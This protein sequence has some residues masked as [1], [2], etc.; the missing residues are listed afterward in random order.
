MQKKNCPESIITML[1]P[2]VLKSFSE[3]LNELSVIDDGITPMDNF[4]AQKHTLHFKI[5]AHGVVQ[6]MSWMKDY[7]KT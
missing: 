4:Q 2:Y 1:W 6:F 5:T 3:K 7:K